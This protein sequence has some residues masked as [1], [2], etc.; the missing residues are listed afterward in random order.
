MSWRGLECCTMSNTRAAN[1]PVARVLPMLGLAHL[2]RAFDYLVDEQDAEAAQ[3][4]VRVRVRFAGR[5]VDAIVLERVSST[6]HEGSLRFI[7]RVISPEVVAPE[8]TRMLIDALADRYAGIRSDIYR[9]AIP[10]R[11]AKAE[12]T[13]TSTPWVELGEVAEPD[14][15]AWTTYTHG[16][17]FVDAV[18]E[19]KLA[20]AAWQ[21]VPGEDWPAALAA[22]AV[23]VAKDGGGALIVVPDQDAVDR[24]E[25]ALR[26]LVAAKQ[27]TTLTASQGPQARYSRYLSV[28]HGQGR[29]TLR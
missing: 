4:G 28:L 29:S 14:L 20:R 18:V 25:E 23:K 24:C 1:L 21:L 6:S 5:L 16:E 8:H 19:G 7:E 10:A 3:P 26:E 11:H 17:S 12:E 27:V 15:S 22:L 2:D 13:D 9:S